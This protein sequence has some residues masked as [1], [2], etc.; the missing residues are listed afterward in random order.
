MGAV[1][2][3]TTGT[4]LPPSVTNVA[5]QQQ[6]GGVQFIQGGVPGSMQGGMQG[7]M[8]GSVQG[9]AAPWQQPKELEHDRFQGGAKEGQCKRKCKTCKRQNKVVQVR[10][11][12]LHPCA[13]YQGD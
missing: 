10:N 4:V 13:Y 12:I 9:A 2:V 5:P 7:G 6:T 8:Q 1:A 11:Q 3:G